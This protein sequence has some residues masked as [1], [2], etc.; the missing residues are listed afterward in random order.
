ME[1]RLM[2]HLSAFYELLNGVRGTIEKLLALEEKK[3]DAL[4]QVDVKALM[5]I[6]STEEELIQ[7]MDCLEKE[8]QEAIASLAV[9]LGCGRDV[10][11]GELITYF[12]IEMQEKFGSIR[13][14]LKT[15][16]N[17]LEI[18]MR[19]NSE[20][21]QSSMEIVNFTLNFANRSSLKE[22]Y[23]LRNKKESKENMCIVN[24]IA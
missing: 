12:P 2:E 10:T 20:I 14:E 15:F 1:T 19:E 5:H 16:T 22:T 18:T 4:K 7:Y 6:N 3:Y 24:H 21:I 11:F 17:K 23:D 13:K 9:S 8:R